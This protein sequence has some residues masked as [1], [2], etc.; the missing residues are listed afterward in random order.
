MVQVESRDE[1]EYRSCETGGCEK[2]IVMEGG[3][4]KSGYEGRGGRAE[5]YSPT[6][7]VRPRSW[8]GSEALQRVDFWCAEEIMVSE[9]AHDRSRV[10]EVEND[11]D[12]GL[13]KKRLWRGG[14]GMGLG[15]WILDWSKVVPSTSYGY[16]VSGTCSS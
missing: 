4:H 13:T 16:G 6:G 7:V 3:W 10:L 11:K 5:M 9:L 15:M 2:T 8:A 12:M 1:K 14:Y